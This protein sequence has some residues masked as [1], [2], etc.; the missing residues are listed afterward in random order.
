MT[1]DFSNIELRILADMSHD[2]RMLEMFAAGID[3]HGY[4]ARMMFG[5]DDTVDVKSKKPSLA[6]PSVQSPRRLASVWPM[7]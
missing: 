4:T 1:A 5:V 3:L 6:S 7:A 2:S